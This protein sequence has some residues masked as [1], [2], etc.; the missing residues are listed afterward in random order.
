MIMNSD[1]DIACMMCGKVVIV[2]RKVYDSR[3]VKGRAN[4]ET[5]SGRYLDEFSAMGEQ[6]IRYIGTPHNSS[7]MVGQRGLY[8]N[9]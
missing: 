9:R 2:R 6:R 7:K 5:V 1:K 3:N 4:K 8:R